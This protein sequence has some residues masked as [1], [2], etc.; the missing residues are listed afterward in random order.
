MTRDRAAA[1]LQMSPAAMK[2]ELARFAWNCTPREAAGRMGMSRTVFY[3][4]V[5]E[6]PGGEE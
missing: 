2:L 6:I 5:T 1:M 4:A 3:R